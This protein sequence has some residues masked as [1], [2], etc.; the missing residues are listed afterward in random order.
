MS[1]RPSRRRV[2]ELVVVAD[3]VHDYVNEH[4]PWSLTSSLA[5]T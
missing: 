2:I 5:L 3:H 4:G 1:V